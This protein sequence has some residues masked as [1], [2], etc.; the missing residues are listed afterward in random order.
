ML[1]ET[2]KFGDTLFLTRYNMWRIFQ[3]ISQNESLLIP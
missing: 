2:D 3:K 1:K